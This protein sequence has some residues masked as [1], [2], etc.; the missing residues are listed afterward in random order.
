[1]ALLVSDKHNGVKSVEGFKA[2]NCMNRA[3]NHTKLRLT[4]D[5][6]D[7]KRLRKFQS[8]MD[9]DP[10][11]MSDE[12]YREFL[13]SADEDE[14]NSEDFNEGEDEGAES[15]DKI[16]EYRQ[17]L[18]GSLTDSKGPDNMFRKRDLQDGKDDDLDIKFNVGF[19]EDV[20]KTL[21]SKKKER[22]ELDDETAW[23]SY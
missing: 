20:G 13:A 2:S 15:R 12:D 1:M 16:E 23:E 11:K 19:G 21:I 3:L 7:P 10:D 18:L 6:T 14:E 8:I 5:E 9:Q 17:K 22:K 4:W